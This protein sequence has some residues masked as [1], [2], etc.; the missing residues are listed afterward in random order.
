APD[1]PAFDD[2]MTQAER[3]LLAASCSGFDRG[4]RQLGLLYLKWAVHEEDPE[5]RL[6]LAKKADSALGQALVF[7]PKAERVWRESAA[8][9]TLLP[10]KEM[11]V[12]AKS[13]RAGELVRKQNQMEFA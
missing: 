10:G 13:Q 11:E 6:N 2:L 12:K 8:A 5:K 9:E 4:A 3:S 1:G 7:E